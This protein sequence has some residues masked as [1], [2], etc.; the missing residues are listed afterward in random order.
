MEITRTLDSFFSRREHLLGLLVTSGEQVSS[1]GG[2]T[3]F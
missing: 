2:T 1:V 3:G